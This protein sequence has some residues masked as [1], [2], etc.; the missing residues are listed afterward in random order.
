MPAELCHCLWSG[1]CTTRGKNSWC[2]QQTAMIGLGSAWMWCLKAQGDALLCGAFCSVPSPV[3]TPPQGLLPLPEEMKGRLLHCSQVSNQLSFPETVG[4]VGDCFGGV[5]FMSLKWVS[6][7]FKHLPAAFPYCA[8]IYFCWQ[9]VNQQLNPNPFPEGA[10]SP[11]SPSPLPGAQPCCAAFEDRPRE[12]HHHSLRACWRWVL[13]GCGAQSPVY[14]RA[15]QAPREKATLFP[16]LVPS[17]EPMKAA[18][19]STCCPHE[20]RLYVDLSH[21]GYQH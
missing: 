1:I 10:G 3:W 8:A 11:L 2:C 9:A 16:P 4:P 15:L 18:S 14:P 17:Q 19:I 20:W 12:V 5:V 6:W 7:V 21:M 13:A